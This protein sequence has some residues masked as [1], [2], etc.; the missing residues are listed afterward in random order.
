MVLIRGSLR[1]KPGNIVPGG[2]G[3]AVYL[4]NYTASGADPVAAGRH[5][6]YLHGDGMVSF[7][8]DRAMAEVEVGDSLMPVL[9]FPTKEHQEISWTSADMTL[10]NLRYLQ[11]GNDVSGVGT[12]TGG[13]DADATG[14]YLYTLLGFAKEFALWI[15]T[16]GLSRV[17]AAARRTIQVFRTYVKKPPEEL[18]GS[19]SKEPQWKVT[20]GVLI[21]PTAIDPATGLTMS[22]KVIDA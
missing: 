16:P 8:A 2:R 18:L 17:G 6:G 20:M 10:E 14:T 22:Y 21:D 15:D 5:V 3:P 19:R 9:A 12:L 13:G 11:Y 7:K 4:A 1:Q